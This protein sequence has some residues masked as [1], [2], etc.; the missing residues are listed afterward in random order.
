MTKL[1]DF[2]SCPNYT[3]EVS[4]SLAMFELHC[5]LSSPCLQTG[6][7]LGF[8]IMTQSVPGMYRYMYMYLWNSEKKVHIKFNGM[9]I[10]GEQAP[11]PLGTFLVHLS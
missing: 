5:I 8:T 9:L 4:L 2:V 1:F 7:W 10:S 6:A 11:T 3:Y